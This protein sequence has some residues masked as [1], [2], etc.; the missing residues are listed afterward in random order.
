ME[1]PTF[2]IYAATANVSV[3][4]VLSIIVFLSYTTEGIRAKGVVGYLKSLIPA[5]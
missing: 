3:P 1:L 4:L 5:G 2:A